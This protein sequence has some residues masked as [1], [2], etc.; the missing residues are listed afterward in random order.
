[1]NSRQLLH[2][3]FMR[4]ALE[5]ARAAAARGEVPVGAV[6]VQNGRI[7]AR[8]GNTREGQPSALG[9]AELSVIADGCRA[10]GRW[11]LSDCTLYVTLEPCPM[12]AGAAVNARLGAVVYGAY[13]PAAGCLGS[14]INLFALDFNYRPRIV[15]G[16][17]EGECRALLTEFFGLQRRNPPKYQ[18]EREERK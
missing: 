7:I 3:G 18:N 10:L 4:A 15:A 12:C 5:E 9:H 13:D 17:L 11:R 14:K 8:A 16:V 6:L 2:E 1:M